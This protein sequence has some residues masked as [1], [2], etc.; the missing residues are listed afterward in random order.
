MMRAL[1]IA[2]S[3]M[4]AQQF[5]VDVISNNLSNVN[6]TGYK[7]ERAEFK[8]MLYETLTR[9]SVLDG[10]GRPVNL[11]VGHGAVT[12]ATS[13]NF[14]MG[15]LE[16]T[17]NPLDFAIDGD[18]FFMVAGRGGEIVYT[19]DGSFKISVT[20]FGNMLTT[21]D[22]YPVLDENGMEII[23]DV[24]ISRLS[25]REDGELSYT[26]EEGNV[27]SLGQRIGLVKFPNRYGLE[28]IGNNNYAI[29]PASGQPVPDDQMG[30]RSSIRQNFLESSNV[31][32]VEEMV[33][34]I[35]A[36]RAYE[37]NSK[38]IQSADDM[39]GIANNLKR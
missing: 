37:I 8:D 28:S 39:L 38:A 11:Q 18:G 31:Q 7:K 27:V 5:N 20:D 13:K 25:V 26:D 30:K 22:G 12:A 35:V 2:S 17:D 9:A 36:Q 32:V 33:K 15:N 4:K 34:L 1:W 6:T 14:Q 29:T 16:R 21:S 10:E 3:G 19:R 23:I 24:D